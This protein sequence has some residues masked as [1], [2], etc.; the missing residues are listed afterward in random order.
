MSYCLFYVCYGCG[1][2]ASSS[3]AL[4]TNCKSDTDVTGLIKNHLKFLAP[5]GSNL[6]PMAESYSAQTTGYQGW[7][8][9]PEFVSFKTFYT[10][11]INNCGLCIGCGITLNASQ[12][13]ACSNCAP[14]LKRMGITS[15]SG[16]PLPKGWCP[17]Y[18]RMYKRVNT[19]PPPVVPAPKSN[20]SCV[21]LGC[22]N[23]I[24]KGVF[25]DPCANDS[26][27]SMIAQV[28]YDQGVTGFKPMTHIPAAFQPFKAF[29]N[30]KQDRKCCPGCGLTIKS[31]KYWAC[32]D[33]APICQQ[34]N[35][36]Y[37]KSIP[38]P[39]TTSSWKPPNNTFWVLYG[40]QPTAKSGIF[41]DIVMS[42]INPVIQKKVTYKPSKKCTK[43]KG[44]WSS[45]L[46]AYY[47]KDPSKADQ[48]SRCR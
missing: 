27:V 2:S 6:V 20:K 38:F 41:T 8:C 34:L 7:T 46:D 28:Y 32:T 13:F 12:C 39:F 42:T 45:F 15:H 48:C 25:C 24:A 29:A 40:L 22:G 23:D 33:C 5:D 30:Q 18:E 43:C 17:G 4:C 10:S 21:C 16:W 19:Q 26:D 44:D 9:P 37:N 1:R 36:T 11:P 35:I 31:D 47:G 14:D 3:Q